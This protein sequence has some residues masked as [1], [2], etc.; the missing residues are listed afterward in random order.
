MKPVTYI[1]EKYPALSIGSQQGREV[2]FRR[3]RFVAEKDWQVKM[4]EQNEWF[5]CFIFKGEDHAPEP[6]APS[7]QAI[8]TSAKRGDETL[9]KPPEGGDQEHVAEAKSGEPS[10]KKGVAE[11]EETAVE[12][13]VPPDP[14]PMGPRPSYKI[15]KTALEILEKAGVNPIG[16]CE[17]MGLQDGDRLT[18]KMAEE[19]VNE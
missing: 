7:P 12:A 11:Q 6:I 10:E 2:K 14:G 3:G 17:T 8:H 4:I 5:G 15:S 18:V 9:H 1:C 19:F 13:E 16:A